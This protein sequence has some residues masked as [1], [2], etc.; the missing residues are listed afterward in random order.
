MNFNDIL[1]L[2]TAADQ[3][4]RGELLYIDYNWIHEVSDTNVPEALRTSATWAL[5]CAR[6]ELS[7]PPIGLRW[8]SLRPGEKAVG[9]HGPSHTIISG[10]DGRVFMYFPEPTFWFGVVPNFGD[11]KEIWLNL[12]QSADDVT[13]TLFHEVRHVWQYGQPEWLAGR[14]NLHADLVA[15]QAS[16]RDADEFME[17]MLRKHA[18]R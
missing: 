10:P 6:A 12:E 5:E 4:R 8:V 13:R 17:A 1:R 3:R 11:H 2:V 9:F 18:R 16:E 15:Y 7:L 14:T